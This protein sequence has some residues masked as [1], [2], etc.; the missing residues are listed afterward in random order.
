LLVAD[1]DLGFVQSGDACH[2]LGNFGVIKRRSTAHAVPGQQQFEHHIGVDAVPQQMPR[3]RGDRRIALICGWSLERKETKS[4]AANSP[5][6]P[7]VAT[8]CPGIL[9][10]ARYWVDH[11][12]AAA[13][14]A[15]VDGNGQYSLAEMTVNE[16]EESRQQL[17][18]ETMGRYLPTMVDATVHGVEVSDGIVFVYSYYIDPLLMSYRQKV[19]WAIA[20]ACNL[21]RVGLGNPR[22]TPQGGPAAAVGGRNAGGTPHPRGDYG[23]Q[24]PGRASLDPASGLTP[25]CS[26]GRWRRPMT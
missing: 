20:F 9:R 25:A 1:C 14:S 18:L 15:V 2:D 26:S 3:E 7:K 13:A 19:D 6:K 12:E 24:H 4:R 5:L 10:E 16:S 17:P 21:M 11:C 22:W 8:A 23:R